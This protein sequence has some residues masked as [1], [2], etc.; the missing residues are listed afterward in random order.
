MRMSPESFDYILSLVSP[1]ISHCP[2]FRFRKGRSGTHCSPIGQHCC[3]YVYAYA[4]HV[5]TGCKSDI[6]LSISIRRTQGFDILMLML[7]LMLR[8]SSLA[9]K[10]LMPMLMLMLASL[11]R[12][13]LN[14]LFHQWLLAHI[15]NETINFCI[16]R[17][18]SVH[19]MIS[20]K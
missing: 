5:L 9:H 11:V 17:L 16:L 20:K 1:L 4:K 19:L 14:V 15:S 8:S 12:T 13:G 3:A 7:A 2:P 18:Q 10:L 6:S